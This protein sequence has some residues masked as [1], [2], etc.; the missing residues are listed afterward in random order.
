MLLDLPAMPVFTLAGV[1]EQQHGPQTPRWGE[2]EGGG[3]PQLPGLR[4]PQILVLL[5]NPEARQR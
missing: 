3:R 2:K 4:R 5:V 1:G